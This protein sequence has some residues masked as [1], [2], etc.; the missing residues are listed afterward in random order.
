MHARRVGWLLLLALLSCMIAPS[1]FAHN[2][3]TDFVF[4]NGNSA[5]KYGEA[6]VYLD[7]GMD[8]WTYYL[9]HMHQYF[10]TQGTTVRG[11]DVEVRVYN[12]CSSESQ[13]KSYTPI[14]RQRDPH[15]LGHNS[16]YGH[17]Y[18]NT[19]TVWNPGEKMLVRGDNYIAFVHTVVDHL[20]NTLWYDIR[21]FIDL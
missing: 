11:W 21:E 8:S 9:R 10:S 3:S 19:G 1:V 6:W 2:V 12:G 20:T 14:Y 15:L 16:S 13:C 7:Q 5:G 17:E 4:Y 18:P